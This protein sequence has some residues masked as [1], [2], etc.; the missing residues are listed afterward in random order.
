MV[1][2]SGQ[3]L[4]NQ[5]HSFFSDFALEGGTTDGRKDFLTLFNLVTRHTLTSDTLPSRRLPE[6]D[7]D[8]RNNE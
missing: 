6:A 4:S 7:P 3:L 1:Q 5:I 2:G 8:R